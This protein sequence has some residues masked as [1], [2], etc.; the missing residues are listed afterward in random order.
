MY[1]ALEAN[2][3]EVCYWFSFCPIRVTVVPKYQRCCSC[4]SRRSVRWGTLGE[5]SAEW[6]TDVMGSTVLGSFLSV[7]LCQ[8]ILN[9]EKFMAKVAV[10]CP[11][12]DKC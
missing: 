11:D 2:E 10:V 6:R 5:T 4:A 12:G 1:H 8:S 7:L 9:A 3:G